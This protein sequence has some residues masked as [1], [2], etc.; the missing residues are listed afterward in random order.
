VTPAFAGD[1]ISALVDRY[2]LSAGASDRL[3][4]LAELLAQPAAPTA[5][6]DPA[7][8]VDDH[9]A[10]SLVGLELAP[11]RAARRIAD[12]GAGAGLPGLALAVALPEA[13]VTLIESNRRKVEFIARAI[14]ACELDNATAVATRAELW[15]DGLAACDLVTARALA[16]LPVVAE[17]AAPL[18]TGGGHLVAW[19]GR[20]DADDE[21]AGARAAGELGLE[22]LPALPVIPYPGALHRHLHVMRKVAPTPDRFPR[23]PGMARKRPLG[24]GSGSASDR[25]RR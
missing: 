3:R 13:H 6:H 22:L 15:H 1:R 16:P 10:D 9:L 14:A 11:V 23:R 12:L 8:I 25:P 18:L 5:V 19:R 24:A 17:Y 4:R 21:A 20:R 7:G 2:R